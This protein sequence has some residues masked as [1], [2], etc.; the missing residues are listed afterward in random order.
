MV[1]ALGL[2]ALAVGVA[3]V[4]MLV[5]WVRWWRRWQWALARLE[6]VEAE[7]EAWMQIAADGAALA[8]LYRAVAG[9]REEVV[10]RAADQTVPIMDGWQMGPDFVIFTHRN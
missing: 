7:R 9:N 2:F 10:Q 8:R 1:N 4:A 3:A 6:R 5:A